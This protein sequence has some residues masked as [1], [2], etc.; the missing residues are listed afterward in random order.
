RCAW[1]RRFSTHMTMVT[2]RLGLPMRDG[3]SLWPH[4]GGHFSTTIGG[5]PKRPSKSA[6]HGLPAGPASE[7]GTSPREPEESVALIHH[8][9]LIL[10]PSL[11][12]ISSTRPQE[13]IPK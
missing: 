1:T 8:E 7:S 3:T 4:P 6:V 9:K 12:P 2:Y 5:F 13:I 10:L 11:R